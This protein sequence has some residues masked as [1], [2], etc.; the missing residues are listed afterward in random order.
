MVIR[1]RVIA[2][3]SR[4]AIFAILVTM[5]VF[6]LTG[7]EAWASLLQFETSCAFF[8]LIILGF[9]ILFN[10]IDLRRGM[11]GIAAGFYMPVNLVMVGFCFIANVG[12]F[13]YA[14]PTGAASGS[15]FSI[16]F[17]TFFM[18]LPVLEW[19]LFDIKGTVRWYT[20]FT[21]MLFP[22][23]YVVF[24]GFRA[25]IWPDA[26]LPNG[27]MYPYPYLKPSWGPFVGWAILTFLIVYGTLLAFT[28]F[29][30]ILS[31]KYRRGGDINPF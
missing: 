22:V 17:H 2:L 15:I 20:S 11:K 29:N 6:Y 27:S 19:L 7:T 5:T 1:N 25:L 23:F 21:A 12:Y 3:L 13:V 10:A 30:N 28:L 8:Y 31:G 4:L 26:T 16:L 24:C 14:L 9:A 18:T